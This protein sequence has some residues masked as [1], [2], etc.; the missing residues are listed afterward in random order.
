MK[1]LLD[2][3]VFITAKNSYYAFDI[4][5]AFWEWLETEARNGSLAST[6]LVLDELSKHDD[7]LAQWA[8]KHKKTIFYE[9]SS[10]EA[11]A[12]NINKIHRWA[13]KQ[14]YKQHVISN[15]MNGADPFLI[16]V[17]ADLGDIV[18]TLEAPAPQSKRSIKIPDVCQYLGVSYE[19]TFKMMRNLN[20]KFTSTATRST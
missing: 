13:V 8:K 11:I 20:A 6:D 4:V 3:N 15:F 2:A 5:P 10:S 17:A 9:E 7:E 16:A 19:N 18:V 14:G 1:R 12:V